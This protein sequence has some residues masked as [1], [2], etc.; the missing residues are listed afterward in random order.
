MWDC[1]CLFFRLTKAVE[2]EN[3]TKLHRLLGELYNAMNEQD[4]ALHHHNIANK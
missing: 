3:N 4:K 1:L 2:M